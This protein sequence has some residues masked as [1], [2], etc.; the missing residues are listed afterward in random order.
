MLKRVA[1]YNALD[2]LSELD[3]T[4]QSFH[5]LSFRKGSKVYFFDLYEYSRYFDNRLKGHFLY[6]DNT[7]I[8]DQPSLVKSRPIRGDNKNA[9]IL[10]WNKIRH[11]TFVKNERKQ[12]LDKKDQLVFR[13]NIHDCQPHRIAFMEMHFDNPICNVG[14]V[15]QN[16]LNPEWTVD[17]MSIDDQLEYKF[18]LCLEG[19]DVATNLKWV[20]SSQSLAVM[21]RPKY[22]TWFMEGKLIPDFHYIEINDDY[23]NLNQKL[24]YYINHPD[25][26]LKIIANA[27]NY[28]KQFQDQKRED[29]ISLLVLKKYFEKTG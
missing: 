7:I 28:V 20:M 8:P 23:S 16:K 26:A 15:N 22:E 10:K 29:I 13:G 11:F 2:D 25:E 24:N 9:V 14:K 6:G 4:A 21:P 3:S 19:A 12:F 27:N 5:E 1:Y 17:W 18:I